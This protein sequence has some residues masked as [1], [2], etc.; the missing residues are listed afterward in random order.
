MLTLRTATLALLLV[1]G[2]AHAQPVDAG[3][4]VTELRKGGYLVFFRHT[5]TFRDTA[6][7]E[8][9]ARNVA[10]GRLV[11]DDCTTQRNLNERGVLEAARQAKVVAD[12]RIPYGSVY[13][14]R[15]CR[16][17]EHARWFTTGGELNDALTPV[18]N[19]DK[20]KALR[21]MLATPPAAG[22]NTFFFA[23]G[24]ILWQATDYDS[25]EAETFVFRAGSPPALV[26]AIKMSD[27]D[28]L[29]QRNGPCC[30][31]RSYWAGQ[32]PPKD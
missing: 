21:A 29:A 22:T 24:G 32:G 6:T 20:A 25:D 15:Y 12:L 1:A 23:H 2:A 18:R 9:E 13:V 26:A 8:M 17:R 4:L 11:V 16:A 28:A 5:S 10:S 3:W 30:A 7:M 14:S 31:P 19:A 27:W